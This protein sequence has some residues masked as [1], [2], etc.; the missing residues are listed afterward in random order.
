MACLFFALSILWSAQHSFPFSSHWPWMAQSHWQTCCGGLALDAASSVIITVTH[1]MDSYNNW[2]P[3]TWFNYENL[4]YR[5]FFLPVL[6]YL[7]KNSMQI[8]FC[9][10]GYFVHLL[11][12]CNMKIPT[13]SRWNLIKFIY[14]TVCSI[15]NCVASLPTAT[16]TG[17]FRGLPWREV[18][19][20]T[21]RHYNYLT[22]YKTW[23]YL[24]CYFYFSGIF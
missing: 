12:Y 5:V 8:W 17:M 10:S 16:Y 20:M 15:I 1:M 23:S 18:Y 21:N 2:C 3:P 11:H 19:E 9:F 4:C 6:Y 22:V 24:F 13:P 7:T 14:D